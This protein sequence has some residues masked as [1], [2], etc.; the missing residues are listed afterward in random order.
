MH[1]SREEVEIRC[2]PILNRPDIISLVENSNSPTAA[3]D[4]VMVACGDERTAK[5][6]RW[7]GILRRDYADAYAGLTNNVLHHATEGTV[8]EETNEEV[9]RER[10]I[11]PYS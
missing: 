6:A 4:I 2:R 9:L 8:K 5:A 3:F 1:R 7:L 11:V 10:P